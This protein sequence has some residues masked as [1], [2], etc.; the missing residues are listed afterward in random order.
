M[1]KYVTVDSEPLGGVIGADANSPGSPDEELVVSSGSEI[2]INRISPDEGA[3][4]ISL[5]TM[6]R[7]K[8]EVSLR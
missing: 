7:S 8:A 4:M 3:V 5:G 2:L 1:G 6:S